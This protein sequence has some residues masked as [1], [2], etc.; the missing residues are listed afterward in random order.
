MS[1]FYY[2]CAGIIAVV[3]FIAAFIIGAQNIASAGSVLLLAIALTVV[4][5]FMG[6]TVE[7]LSR[8]AGTHPPKRSGD[9]NRHGVG[10]GASHAIRQTG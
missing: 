3:G 10:R 9:V 2:V 4:L 6:N 7:L 1:Y 8:I 5:V